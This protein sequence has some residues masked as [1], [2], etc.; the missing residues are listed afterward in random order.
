M[1]SDSSIQP[2]GDEPNIQPTP[3]SRY[4]AWDR[5]DE[6]RDLADEQ[7]RPSIGP[8]S[9]S[10]LG[11]LEVTYPWRPRFPACVGWGMVYF[12]V[13][14]MAVVFFWIFAQILPAIVTLIGLIVLNCFRFGANQALSAKGIQ[15]LQQQSIAPTLIAGH[16]A[17]ISSVLV[18]LRLLL[19]P[20]WLRRLAV[21]LPAWWHLLLT[22]LFI[23]AIILLANGVFSV[24]KHFLPNM[25]EL[26]HLPKDAMGGMEQ[27]VKLFGTWPWWLAVLVVG[28]GPAVS[29][30]LW[31]RG[32][33]GLGLLGRNGVVARLLVTAFYF[34]VLHIDPQQGTMAA[35]MGL[36]LYFVLLTTRCFW[37]PVL[38]HFG[39]N[40]TSVIAAHFETASAIDQRPEE[41]PRVLTLGAFILFL[42][43]VISLYRTRARLANTL[44]GDGPLSWQ[45]TYAGLE[46]PPA[47]C[48]VVVQRPN[49]DLIDLCLLVFGLTAGA[50]AIAWSVAFG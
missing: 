12:A 42:T 28:L 6:R 29:E 27:M 2:S 23:P 31:C 50:A 21:R 48:G 9:N 16:F 36:T 44:G 24:A 33:L 15:Y 40:S 10:M 8:P 14:F 17:A 35:I 11:F 47:G 3:T 1:S 34:G 4:D 13:A 5:G 43:I 7:R 22:V 32:L 25:G 49:P 45:P 30:E 19:G 38:I 39:V 41:I 20:D 18:F 37:M 46:H 26:L